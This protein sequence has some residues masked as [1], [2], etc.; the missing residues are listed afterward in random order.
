MW[1]HTCVGTCAYIS[2]C[3]LS[4]EDS[5][6][7]IDKHQLSCF[8]WQGLSHWH[9]SRLAAWLTIL[10]DWPRLCLL[11]AG[12]T[13]TCHCV[14]LLFEIWFWGLHSGPCACKASTILTEPSPSQSK[15]ILIEPISTKLT[16]H[17]STF[18]CRS[19]M[20]KESIH[21]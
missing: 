5:L 8:L 3:T 15:D 6:G 19:C 18:N 21:H 4:S 9:A 17:D 11:S 10:R 1:L 20:R 13:S 12:I 14:W 7:F 16:G 2:A